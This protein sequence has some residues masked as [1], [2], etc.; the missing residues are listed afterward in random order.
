M[1]ER[2]DWIL[3]GH[4]PWRRPALVVR[5]VRERFSARA[6][7]F[8][9]LSNPS[10]LARFCS[11][12]PARHSFQIS[13]S[14]M[15][16]ASL[17]GA[18]CRRGIDA[19]SRRGRRRRVLTWYKRNLGSRGVPSTP[20]SFGATSKGL[21]QVSCRTACW[22]S[23]TSRPRPRTALAEDQPVWFDTPCVS[24]ARCRPS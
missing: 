8:Q 4:L 1:L 12:C 11:A 17:G 16:C 7:I 10:V 13:S 5:I 19:R 6:P 15:L 24:S 22:I 2:E 20:A 21:V 3:A 9:L 18:G 23:S 14:S